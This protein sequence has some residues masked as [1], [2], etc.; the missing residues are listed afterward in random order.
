MPEIVKSHAALLAEIEATQTP[1]GEAAFWWMGQHTFIIKAG[2]TVI[3]IDPWFA[4][5]E[6]RNTPPPLDYAEAKFAD[7]VLITHGHGDHLCPE[8]LKVMK[9]VS[10][11]CHFVCPKSELHRLREEAGIPASRI[12]PMQGKKE[13]TFGSISVFALPAK[14]ET[15][16]F[17]EENG[18]PFL[19]YVVKVNGVTLYH[20]GD[21]IFHSGMLPTLTHRMPIDVAFL[22]INGR[23]AAQLKRNLLGNMTYQEAVEVAGELKVGLAVPAHYDMFVGNQEDPALFVDYLALRYPEVKHWVGNIGERVTISSGIAGK[24]PENGTIIHDA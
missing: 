14:H 19:G 11:N 9:D 18:Y 10:P 24:R 20:A 13:T 4:P 12:T 3:Y 16:N 21:T 8:T 22:P 15:F 5:W 17:T 2:E 7:Y 6:G 23:S 1:F